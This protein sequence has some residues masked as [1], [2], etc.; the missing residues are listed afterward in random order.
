MHAASLATTPAPATPTVAWLFGQPV[1]DVPTDLFIPPDALQVVLQSFEGPLDLLLYL[2]RKQNIDV[3]DIPMRKITEQY[4]AYIAQMDMREL[5]LTAEYLLMAAMLIEIKSR[6]LLPPK[7]TA[8]GQ[9]PEDPR[10]EL[11]RRLLE[12]EQMKLAATR[13]AEVPQFGRDFLRAQVYVEQ[14]LKPRLPDVE[15]ADIQQAWAD[16]LK[17]AKLVQHHKISREELSVR[18]HMSIVLRKLQGRRFAPFEDLFDPAKGVPVLV[19]TLIAL[20]ELAKESL[21]EVTQAEAYAPIYVRLAFT[22]A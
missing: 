19:V 6:M 22:P 3:L 15:L 17:R 7:K 14:A 18:E 21:V 1:L 11:V 16:I 20:L 10:A 2:I 12:Y 8:E 5:D 13:I 9:E 4:L